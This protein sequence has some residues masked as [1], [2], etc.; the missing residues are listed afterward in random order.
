MNWNDRDASKIF[1]A[2]DI[3]NVTR[4]SIAAMTDADKAALAKVGGKI[5]GG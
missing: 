3:A 1:Y 2:V 4:F 5:K